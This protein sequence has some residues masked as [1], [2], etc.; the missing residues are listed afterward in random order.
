MKDKYTISFFLAASSLCHLSPVAT[1][2]EPVTFTEH[3]APIIHQRCTQ[4]H[5]PDE[6]APFTLI[7]YKQV[8]K[9]SRT[10]HEV[11]NDRYMPPWHPVPD[12]GDFQYERRLS[13]KELVLYNTWM[14]TGRLEGDPARMPKAPEFPEGWQL[15]EPDLIVEMTRS[16]D[17]PADGPDIYRSFVLP[18]NLDEDKWVK[19]VELRPQARNVVHHVLFFL[20]DSGTAR[21]LD[22][23]DGKPGFKGMGFRISGRLG[24]YVPGNTGRKLPGDMALPLPKGSDLV[25][26]THFHPVGK[27]E[28]ERFKVGFYFTDKA[29]SKTLVGIQVPPGFGRGM[30]INIPP[31]EKNYRVEDSFTLPID[32]DAH[33]VGGHAH[34]ICS[35]MKMTAQLPDGSLEQLLYI[36]D[37]D[38]NWQDR[39]TYKTPVRLPAGTVI[40]TVLV[41]DN[42]EDNPD[43][44]TI[45]PVRV[46]WGREST[47]EM[48][49]ITLQVTA[50]NEWERFQLTT[51]ALRGSSRLASAALQKLRN[52]LPDDLPATVKLLDRNGDG[53][54]QATEIPKKMKRL[55]DKLDRNKNGALDPPELKA[56]YDWADALKKQFPA[57]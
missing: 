44:P 18:L 42:S 34:Y 6:A 40:K 17:V 39:Y 50:V 13:D 26:Q 32:V 38:L 48:G 23:K 51:A 20:D 10:I 28:T 54:L 56:L 27:A 22:G 55:L 7:S 31:G 16:I 47:D 25:L 19:A 3:I 8:R 30:K 35:E 14:D 2:E 37:W 41:Y 45:P 5:R 9:H 33:I 15:G 24:G 43:N 52:S 21:E 4:C 36:D 12:H 57:D 29:P 53:T 1:A 49:S 46:K 11:L